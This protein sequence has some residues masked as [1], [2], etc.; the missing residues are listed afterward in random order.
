MPSENDFRYWDTTEVP[1]DVE[2][3]LL[4]QLP[5]QIARFIQ[6][7]LLP[8]RKAC[9]INGFAWTS[10]TEIVC[11]RGTTM[12]KICSLSLPAMDVEFAWFCSAGKDNVSLF[13]SPYPTLDS[14]GVLGN[15]YAILQ[16]QSQPIESVT[17]I[18]AL[19]TICEQIVTKEH[20]IW[21]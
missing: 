7:H 16:N 1:Y 6:T 5:A 19:I 3:E 2:S 18:Q 11:I 13:S 9:V 8:E 14:N 17:D 4:A 15:R 21:D 20:Y 12:I 10:L